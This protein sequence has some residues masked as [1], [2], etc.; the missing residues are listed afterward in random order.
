[1]VGQTEMTRLNHFGAISA[2]GQ[3]G[4]DITKNLSKPLG[5]AATTINQADPSQVCNPVPAAMGLLATCLCSSC[6][7]AWDVVLSHLPVKALVILPHQRFLS[8]AFPNFSNRS[9]HTACQ[10]S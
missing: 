6:S 4:A 10:D 5:S 1:M 3:G 8:N 2:L 7:P 9:T